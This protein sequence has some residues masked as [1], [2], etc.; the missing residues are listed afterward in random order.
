MRVTVRIDTKVYISQHKACR[1]FS[2]RATGV[3]A[4]LRASVLEQV[5]CHSVT[6]K[7]LP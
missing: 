6:D 2:R 4:V 5:C 7:R 3:E 1:R